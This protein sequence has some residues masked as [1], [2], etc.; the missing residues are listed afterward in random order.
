LKNVRSAEKAGQP[1]KEFVDRNYERFFALKQALDL[2]Y[3]DF[4]RTTESRHIAAVQKL[5][6]V[7]SKDIY[8]KNMEGFT[9]LVA[10]NFIKKTS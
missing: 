9:V 5:W 8:K 3:D 2:S 10:K 6:Q 7:C 1:I 4:V